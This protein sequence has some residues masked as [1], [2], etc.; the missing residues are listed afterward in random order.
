MEIRTDRV[1]RLTPVLPERRRDPEVR[2]KFSS[3][4]MRTFL[5]IAGAWGLT[6]DEQR[7]LLGWPAPST[8]FK[9]KSGQI[10]TLSYDTLMR[11]SLIL[12]IYKALHI[13]FPEASLADA[14]LK[15]PNS[16]PM[17]AGKPAMSFL[18]ENG[19]DGLYQLRRLLDARC[20][21]EY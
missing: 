19:M 18:L 13:L 2:R 8:F 20:G 6:V 12:G 9:Y 21:G 11:I 16:N 4:A 7:G 17:F 3:P 5:S 15:L 14:W 10:G 1:G